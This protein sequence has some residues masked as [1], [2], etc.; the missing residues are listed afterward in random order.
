MLEDIQKN[1]QFSKY[2]MQPLL[3]IFRLVYI[4][5]GGS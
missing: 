4:I 5:R 2:T 3:Y 1:I